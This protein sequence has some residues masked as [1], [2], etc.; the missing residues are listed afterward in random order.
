[1][2]LT[3]KDLKRSR[4]LDRLRKYTKNIIHVAGNAAEIQSG[5][6]SNRYVLSVAPMF[7][8]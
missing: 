2:A 3:Y 5:Y 1:M 6:L 8:L 4:D 7:S